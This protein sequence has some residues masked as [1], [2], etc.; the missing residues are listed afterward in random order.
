M[1]RTINAAAVAG[2]LAAL[3][4]GSTLAGEASTPSIAAE[5]AGNISSVEGRVFHH[6]GDTVRG[7]QLD[8]PK[9]RPGTDQHPG[10]AVYIGDSVRSKRASSARLSLADDSR[11]IL[12]E[13]STISFHGI[14]KVAADK[15]I[16][17]FD[18]RKQ[19]QA[20]GLKVVTKTAVIGVKGTRFLVDASDDTLSIYLSEGNIAVQSI[21]G[22][23]KRHRRQIKDE[24]EA[25]YEKQREA[26]QEYL[27]GL[28]QEFVE[29]VKEFE[30]KAN[31]AIIISNQE[32]RDIEIPQSI[33]DEF[34][35]FD[36][37]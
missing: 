18:I 23:F 28:Q 11:I 36:Q 13:R 4:A 3:F 26:Y 35:Q 9:K 32:V 29:Y 16:I 14:K 17:L 37:F 30:M 1:H 2:F 25:Y 7:Q 19:G 27:K 22:E 20:Q 21:E 34:K 6:K 8:I 12:K 15:G 31:S 24:A 10:Y 33:L 5:R